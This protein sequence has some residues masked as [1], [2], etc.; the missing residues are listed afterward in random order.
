[1]EIS[2]HAA[3]YVWQIDGTRVKKAAAILPWRELA[4]LLLSY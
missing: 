3:A 1:M 4:L 2:S